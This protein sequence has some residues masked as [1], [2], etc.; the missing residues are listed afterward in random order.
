MIVVILEFIG[1]ILAFAFWPE[2][3]SYKIHCCVIFL[4]VSGTNFRDL[5]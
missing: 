3:N 4:V 2:V 5:L 1:G